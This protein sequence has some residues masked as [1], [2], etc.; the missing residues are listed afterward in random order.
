[1]SKKGTWKQTWPS[2][3][4]KFACSTIQDKIVRTRWSNPVNP[5]K[6]EKVWYL[7]LHVFYCSLQ[8]LSS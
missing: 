5:D 7:F 6:N 4:K 2:M 8:R 3:D 1:M